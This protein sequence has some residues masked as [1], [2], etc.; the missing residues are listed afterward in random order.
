VITVSRLWVVVAISVAAIL[1]YRFAMPPGPPHPPEAAADPPWNLRLKRLLALG[2]EENPSMR[3]LRVS[4]HVFEARSTGVLPLAMPPLKA[5]AVS[6]IGDR[7]VELIRET[8][9]YYNRLNTLYPAAQFEL[10]SAEE[11][12]L[13]IPA[14]WE[15]AASKRNRPGLVFTAGIYTVRV[16]PALLDDSDWLTTQI[17]VHHAGQFLLGNRVTKAADEKPVVIGGPIADAD[18]QG[19]DTGQKAIFVG[20]VMTFVPKTT[21]E[22]A[23]LAMRLFSGQ[24]FDRPPY[25]LN[26]GEVSP[27]AVPPADEMEGMS[28]YL[29]HIGADGRVRDARLVVSLGPDYDAAALDAIQRSEFVPATQAKQTVDSWMFI[30]IQFLSSR[31][32]PVVSAPQAIEKKSD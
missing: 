3:Y 13:E 26:L 9:Q 14:A 18:F 19:R 16:E 2:G 12:F 4:V 8:A 25:L 1:A 29:T 20:V 27:P 7:M 21:V 30:P 23:H 28:I 11:N 15:P 32:M 31:Q 17:T 5:A 24:A 6:H 10:I 22:Q